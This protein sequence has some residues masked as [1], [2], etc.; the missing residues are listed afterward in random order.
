MK[1]RKPGELKSQLTEQLA[2]ILKRYEG[3]TLRESIGPIKKECE[4]F[5]ISLGMQRALLPEIYIW[6]DDEGYM[7][8]TM[9]A[10]PE[11]TKGN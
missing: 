9:G 6:M 4:D 8:V 10:Y 3:K 11:P 7:N 1:K 2:A 5:L